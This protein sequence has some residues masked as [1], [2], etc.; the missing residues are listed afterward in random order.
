VLYQSAPRLF[1]DL[2]LARGDDRHSRI[3]RALGRV[4]RLILDDWGLEPLDGVAR[5]GLLEILEDR[6]GRRCT[7]VTSPLLPFEI[8]W[9]CKQFQLLPMA[10]TYRSSAARGPKCPFRSP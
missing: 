6:Y 8:A 1:T 5:H 4:D 2:A 10:L 3:L 7:I 9:V